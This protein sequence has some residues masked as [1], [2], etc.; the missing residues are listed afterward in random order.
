MIHPYYPQK[1]DEP[2]YIEVI[3]EICTLWKGVPH[4][5]AIIRYEGPKYD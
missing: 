2:E 3:L 4:G 1:K 5:P